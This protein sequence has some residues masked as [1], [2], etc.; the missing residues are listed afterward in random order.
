MEVIPGDRFDWVEGPSDP[1]E[2]EGPYD[3]GLGSSFIYINSVTEVH[4]FSSRSA[5][6]LV[7]N[8]ILRKI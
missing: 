7:K 1:V 2:Y 5:E 8:N 4:F 3:K 6:E